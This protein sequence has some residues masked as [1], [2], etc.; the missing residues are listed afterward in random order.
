MLLFAKSEFML[1]FDN[2][3]R[4]PQKS[5]IAVAVG[6]EIFDMLNR[7]V[8]ILL[9]GATLVEVE[10]YLYDARRLH[11][12]IMKCTHKLDQP[13]ISYWLIE[14]PM[15]LYKYFHMYKSAPLQDSDEMIEM[16]CKWMK[17]FLKDH[18]NHDTEWLL[19]SFE[20]FEIGHLLAYAYNY[21][22]FG[23][24][25]KTAYKNASDRPKLKKK[26]Y[27]PIATA[28]FDNLT[29]ILIKELRD[30][31]INSVAKDI[32]QTEMVRKLYQKKL[33]KDEL[34]VLSQFTD[35]MQN[36]QYHIDDEKDENE[37]ENSSATEPPAKKRKMN[38]K[39]SKQKRKAESESDSDNE[40]MDA[41]DW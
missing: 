16:F 4:A 17:T 39:K 11:K 1:C 32:N 10:K 41:D 13:S 35:A 6:C 9:N 40:R 24:I 8:H 37:T 34:N 31:R 26:E 33:T 30:Q 3:A 21:V 19:R 25:D 15:I 2:I 5:K 36:A 38:N 28:P 27:T 23:S 29:K 22:T 18:N 12:Q 14:N 7:Y 20:R